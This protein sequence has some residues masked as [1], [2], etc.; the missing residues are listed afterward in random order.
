APRGVRAARGA[1]PRPA[2]SAPALVCVRVT[3]RGGRDAVTGWDGDT[4]R[5][6]VAAAPSDGAANRAVIDLLARHFG[7]AKRDIELV[8][9]ESSREK[10]VRVGGLDVAA[11]RA[12]APSA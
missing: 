12:R 8:R 5:V 10:W 1:A 11:L 6:R 3:P 2:R 9:G 7:V 4:L